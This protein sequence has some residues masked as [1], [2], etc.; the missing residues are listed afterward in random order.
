[1]PYKDPA[2]HRA[3]CKRYYAKHRSKWP[4]YGK[5]W[6]MKNPERD[7]QL[8]RIRRERYPERSSARRKVQTAIENGTLIKP[9][10][11]EMCGN[12]TPLDGHHEDY[13]KPL[14]VIW[15]CRLCHRHI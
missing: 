8:K 14:D 12:E 2:A 5:D 11:C 4:A 9:L 1:M 3:A 10:H 6:R 13:S 7:A 15:L